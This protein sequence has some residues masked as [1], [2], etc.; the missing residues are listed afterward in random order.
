MLS[1]AKSVELDRR[2]LDN[3]DARSCRNNAC[4][5]EVCRSIE[6]VVFGL[7]AFLPPR[8]D[9]HIEVGQLAVGRGV[10]RK[11]DFFCQEE[12]AVWP[13]RAA[14]V[15]EDS[16]RVVAIPTIWMIRESR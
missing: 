7:R 10:S 3:A 1:R 12:F 2:T 16:H 13:H 4:Q 8:R 5:R 9:Q 14:A 15:R 11:D 6:C